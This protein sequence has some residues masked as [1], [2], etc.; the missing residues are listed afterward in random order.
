MLKFATLMLFIGFD[1]YCI[2]ILL[3]PLCTKGFLLHVLTVLLLFIYSIGYEHSVLVFTTSWVGF[4]FSYKLQKK[5]FTSFEVCCCL[6][7]P[8]VILFYCYQTCLNQEMEKSLQV[9]LLRLFYSYLLLLL[10][11]VGQLVMDI[12]L[13]PNWNKQVSKEWA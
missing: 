12:S 9:L 8:S 3:F 4:S 10:L 7:G 6:P 11:Q 1:F 13:T 2:L 5:Q